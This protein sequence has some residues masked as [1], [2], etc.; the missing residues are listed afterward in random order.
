MTVQYSNTSCDFAD[1][2]I[3]D[4]FALYAGGERHTCMKIEP[5]NI[6]GYNKIVN[7][8]HLATGEV[9]AFEPHQ[10]VEKINATVIVE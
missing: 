4:A 6:E 9:C 3:G 10:K 7:A 8:V 2:W 5:I 1:L